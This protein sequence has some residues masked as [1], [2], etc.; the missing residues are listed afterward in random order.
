MH[1]TKMFRMMRGAYSRE[2][3]DVVTSTTATNYKL[4]V[5]VALRAPL[6]SLLNYTFAF[7]TRSLA[8]K[9]SEI[10]IIIYEYF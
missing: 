5:A 4:A 1:A 3:R 2:H 8:K 10:L 6:L 7:L 9:I